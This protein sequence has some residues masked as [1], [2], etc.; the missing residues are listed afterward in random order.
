M[1]KNDS[2]QDTNVKFMKKVLFKKKMSINQ[3]SQHGLF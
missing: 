3:R 1:Y 2:T